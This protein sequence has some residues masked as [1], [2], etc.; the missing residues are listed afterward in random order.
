MAKL[1][2]IQLNLEPLGG[3]LARVSG[4]VLDLPRRAYNICHHICEEDEKLVDKVIP[5][6]VI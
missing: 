4:G 3:G 1:E 2:A 6:L 5:D